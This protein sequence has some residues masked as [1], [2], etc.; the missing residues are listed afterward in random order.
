MYDTTKW[1]SYIGCSATKPRG[2]GLHRRQRLTK[3]DRYQVTLD[4]RMG[5]QSA[6]LVLW[7]DMGFGKD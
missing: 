7:E 3:A 1:T 2:G 4:R 5:K 6:L